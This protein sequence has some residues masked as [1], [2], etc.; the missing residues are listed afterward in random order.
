MGNI[1]IIMIVIAVVCVCDV[2]RHMMQEAHEEMFNIYENSSTW[3]SLQL[4]VSIQ[5]VHY[6]RVYGL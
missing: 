6:L 3:E 5:C 2:C 1:I 4:A